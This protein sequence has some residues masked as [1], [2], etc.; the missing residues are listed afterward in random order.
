MGCGCKGTPVVPKI[1]PKT[2]KTQTNQTKI[3]I[4]AKPK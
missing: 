2:N 4:S 1:V 3:V